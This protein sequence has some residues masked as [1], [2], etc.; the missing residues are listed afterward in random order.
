MHFVT[1]CCGMIEKGYV[2]FFK[3]GFKDTAFYLLYLITS[4]ADC[5]ECHSGRRR[6][7]GNVALK[8]EQKHLKIDTSV[9][10]DPKNFRE[11]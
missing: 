4:S 6:D 2:Y 10:N 5:K 3:T 1:M 9:L 8:M 11:D 7:V